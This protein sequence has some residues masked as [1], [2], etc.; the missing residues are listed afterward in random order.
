MPCKGDRKKF[1]LPFGKSAGCPWRAGE[2]K[3]SQIPAYSGLRGVVRNEGEFLQINVHFPFC[4][5]VGIS[6]RNIAAALAKSPLAALKVL[7]E[8]HTEEAA[9]FLEQDSTTVPN[10]ALRL[11]LSCGNLV[12]VATPSP[13]FCDLRRLKKSTHERR[14]TAMKRY[15]TPHRHRVIKTRLTEEEYAEFSERVTLCKMSQ[16]EFIR[17][18][19][20][21][22]RI[23]PVITVSPVNDEL[24]SVVGKL[25]A[26]YGKIGGNLNQ[27]ARCLN[28]YGAPYNALSQEVRAAI[29]ELA[30]LKFEVLQKVGEVVGNV[31]TYQL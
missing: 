11:I 15:N 28:E 13:P 1:P 5:F 10:F 18:A 16:A 29:A 17:Q 4:W 9:T 21:K 22:S 23:C 25:T 27:I 30:A 19:L 26:E 20:T 12:G 8:S 6:E 7:R 24:L 3:F 31:Q 2:K 14:F